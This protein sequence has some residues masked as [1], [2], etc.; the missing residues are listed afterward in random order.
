MSIEQVG[1]EKYRIFWELPRGIDGKRRR[2]TEVIHGDYEMAEQ[3]WRKRQ[4]EIDEGRHQEPSKMTVRELAEAWLDTRVAA[5]LDVSTLEWYERLVKVHIIEDLGAARVQKLTAADLQAY[6]RQK[7]QPGAR[8]DG[9]KGALSRRTV[10]ALHSIL[11]GML[12][13]ALRREIVTRNVAELVDVPGDRRT[14]A[15][16]WDDEQA[17]RF[18]TA[19]EGHRLAALW[20]LAVL[21]GL[22]QG[23]LLALRWREVDLDARTL[24]VSRAVKRTK[25]KSRRV[26]PPKS[27]KSRRSISLDETAAAI[28]RAHKARQNEDRLRAG[29]E[30]EAQD[31]V[32]C[33]RQG[34]PLSARNVLR[35]HYQLC[36]KVGVPSIHFH[37]ATRHT[38]ATLLYGAGADDKTVQTRLGHSSASFTKQ[39]Y[40]HA[41]KPKEIAAAEEVGRR[42]MGKKKPSAK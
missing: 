5:D 41:L 21:T 38:H 10:K 29:A 28:L 40:I 11:H 31:L 24:R 4:V 36:A 2:V 7:L 37:E 27:E 13:V 25:E 22:R 9:K 18:L 14:E 15:K 34:R 3:A 8:R 16:F 42:L 33:T 12:K 1:E 35:L 17:T 19:I 30:Y 26:G 39:I 23:E 32:F 6:Y 20:A